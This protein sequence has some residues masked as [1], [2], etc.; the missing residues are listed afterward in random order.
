MILLLAALSLLTPEVQPVKVRV[1]GL[2]NREREADLRAAIKSLP[3]LSIASLDFD[4][5]EVTF[6]CDRVTLLG[7]GTEKQQLERFDT[8]IRNA[9]THTFGIR[10][11]C[12]T[13]KEKL[14]RIDIPVL[15][16]DCRG[17]EL[18]AYEVIFKMD[19]VEQATCSFKAGLMTA[20]IDPEKTSKAALEEALKKR[21]VTL[22]SP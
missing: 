10:P 13:P 11:L 3:E 4:T 20:L 19:G 1:T 12:A 9:S 7:K 22:K 8:L 18:A 16:L 5:S 17:C 21:N 2:F 14:T 15:G 6:S